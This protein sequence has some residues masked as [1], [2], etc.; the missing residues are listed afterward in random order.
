MIPVTY[1]PPAM[2]IWLTKALGFTVLSP[3]Y[4]A[5]TQ[6][7]GLS[8]A[9]R[10]LDY[11]SGSGAAARHLASLLAET[12]GQLDCVDLSPM[13]MESIRNSLSDV[14]N[15]SFHLGWINDLPLPEFVYDAV[16]V[17]YVF[18][19]IP[20]DDLPEVIQHLA[21]KLKPGGRL[22]VREP[23]GQ[24]L[25]IGKLTKLARQAGLSL[26]YASAKDQT[27]MGQYFDAHFHKPYQNQAL[28]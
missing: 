17:H 21:L 15:V 16:V 27:L 2:E 23:E 22:L 12:G 10:V 13:W 24:G 8:G 26:E 9:D 3:Y 5:F 6:Q 7:L 20:A 1:E 25:S 19:E 28:N 14:P 11:G 4:R 18:H